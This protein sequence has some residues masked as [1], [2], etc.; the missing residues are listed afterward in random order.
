MIKIENVVVSGWKA[1]IRGMRNPMNSWMKSDSHVCTE[2]TANDCICP[3]VESG[4]SPCVCND[5]KCGYCIGV[6]DMALMQ[7]LAA[8]G[9]VHGKYLRFITV[10]ADVVAPLY[11]WKE[12]DTYKVG[13]VANSCST[14][15]KIHAKEFDV[16]DFSHEHVEELTGDDYNMSYD[17]LLRTVD[18]LNYYR[19]K[20]LETND[21]KYW[22]QL[23]QLLPSSFNQRRTVLL[24]YAVLANIYQY[25]KEHKLD[26]WRNFCRWIETLPYSEVI[27]GERDAQAPEADGA[28]T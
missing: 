25:R 26:E 28:R 9:S 3:M 1:A 6:N 11:W 20:F 12:Y 18:I 19:K 4:H 5:G 13:T 15:H 16:N 24:N 23:I 7:K 14:M 27:T 21:K 22:W 8:A 2:E 17:F 10:T